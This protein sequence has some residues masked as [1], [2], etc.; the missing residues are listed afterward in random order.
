ME[1]WSSTGKEAIEQLGRYGLFGSRPGAVLIGGRLSIETK[2]VI[3]SIV[4]FQQRRNIF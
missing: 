2:N 4:S 1:Y 3:V